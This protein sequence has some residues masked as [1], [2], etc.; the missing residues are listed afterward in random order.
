MANE[1]SALDPTLRIV[2]DAVMQ[3]LEELLALEERKRMTP[4]DDP[5][6]PE[7]ARQVEDAARRLL[8]GAS[9]QTTAAT[10]VH[11]EAVAE[12]TSATI[13]DIPA[14]VSPTEILARWRD[15]E[16]DLAAVEAGSARWIQLNT[17]VE[18][19]RRA[20]QEAYRRKA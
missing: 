19:L 13:E 5:A 9:G 1:T 3:Q 20:Y 14:D 12:G 2:S 15:A 4:V 7:L 6:F 18:A 8:A 17:Q 10:E 16:R 11:D